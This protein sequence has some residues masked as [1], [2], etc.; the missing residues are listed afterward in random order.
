MLPTMEKDIY[1]SQALVLKEKYNT[2]LIEYRK[3]VSYREYTEYLANFK[4][5]TIKDQ[6]GMVNGHHELATIL[7]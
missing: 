6:I 7:G 3:T 2:E 1:E 4:A 5:K